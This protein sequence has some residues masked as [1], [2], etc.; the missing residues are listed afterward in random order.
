M[1]ETK[2][3]ESESRDQRACMIESKQEKNENL[4]LEIWNNKNLKISLIQ[5]V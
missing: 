1:Y 4:I 5:V 2:R 3:S